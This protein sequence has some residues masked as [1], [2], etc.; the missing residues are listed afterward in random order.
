MTWPLPAPVSTVMYMNRC[1]PPCRNTVP[2]ARCPAVMS[3]AEVNA[4]G[5]GPPGG[6][7]GAGVARRPQPASPAAIAMIV[8]AATLSIRRVRCRRRVDERPLMTRAAKPPG[9]WRRGSS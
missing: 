9:G 8:P 4:A 6:V 3:V 2:M 1:L 5:D 7:D